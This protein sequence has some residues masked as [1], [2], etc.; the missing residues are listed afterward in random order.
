MMSDFTLKS[1]TKKHYII[2]FTKNG[3]YNFKSNFKHEQKSKP[4]LRLRPATLASSRQKT[5]LSRGTRCHVIL[6]ATTGG[7]MAGVS[8]VQVSSAPHSSPRFG[9]F[10]DVCTTA[11]LVCAHSVQSVDTMCPHSERRLPQT[12]IRPRRLSRG[13]AT[14]GRPDGSQ[15]GRCACAFRQSRGHR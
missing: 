15:N 4:K 11:A 5:W 14:A 12:V 10:G 1:L 6:Y 8:E 7:I 3:M 2:C 13:G 9:V